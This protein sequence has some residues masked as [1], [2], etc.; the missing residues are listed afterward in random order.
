MET[1]LGLLGMAGW[2]VAVIVLAA[3]ITYVVMRL[4]PGRDEQL[5]PTTG[6]EPD[7]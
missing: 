7:A 1:V 3:A 2:I 4:F 6:S 5:K